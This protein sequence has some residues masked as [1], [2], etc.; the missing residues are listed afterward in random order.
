V[1][2]KW[3]ASVPITL[4]TFTS[5]KDL[6]FIPR[7]YRQVE[8]AT[9][10]TK[11]KETVSEPTAPN[12]P[13]KAKKDIVPKIDP[14]DVTVNKNLIEK[15]DEVAVVTEPVVEKKK[16]GPAK[17]KDTTDAIVP[18]KPAEPVAPVV[19]E[20]KNVV[21][22]EPEKKKRA[23]AKKKDDTGDG[24]KKK[25]DYQLFLIERLKTIEGKTYKDRFSAAAKEWSAMTP[26]QKVASVAAL[27]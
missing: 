17:K 13:K 2:S 19:E 7:S 4:V 23:P 9:A 12:A 15:L 22:E 14:K 18:A 24:E 11:T 27:K 16:R 3:N 21:P 1:L 25:T 20:T 8:I 26:E 10:P 6:H 5:V